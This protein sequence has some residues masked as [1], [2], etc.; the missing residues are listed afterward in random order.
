MRSNQSKA[1]HH[2]KGSHRLLWRAS[3]LVLTT[4][5]CTTDR[6]P[7]SLERQ[8]TINRVRT[9]SSSN[10]SNGRPVE[11]NLD[12]VAALR[13]SIATEKDPTSHKVL[14]FLHAFVNRQFVE[15]GTRD[16]ERD[17]QALRTS[18]VGLDNLTLSL[19]NATKFLA[20]Q[21]DPKQRRRFAEAVSPSLADLEPLLKIRDRHIA[22]RARE[23]ALPD[24][25]ALA[26]VVRNYDVREAANV[27]S[28]LLKTSDALYLESLRDLVRV[29]GTLPLEE[30]GRP[31]IPWLL[32]GT[33]NI[34]ADRLLAAVHATVMLLDIPLTCL[35]RFVHLPEPI[36]PW[37]LPRSQTQDILHA[38]GHSLHQCGCRAP[39]FELCHLG[40]RSV[41]EAFAVLLE[42]L[43]TEPTWLQEQLGMEEPQL[44]IHLHQAALARLLTARLH[45]A[46]VLDEVDRYG[47][48][49]AQ[50]KKLYAAHMSRALG[51]SFA[52]GD[53]EHY[54]NDRDPFI[55]SA[56]S[57]RGHIIAAQIQ[58]ELITRFGDSWWRLPAAGDF[59][60]ELWLTGQRD[61]AEELLA[62]LGDAGN[63]DIGEN[64]AQPILNPA[65]LVRWTAT[66]LIRQVPAATLPF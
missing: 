39:A 62:R 51:V 33:A 34:E 61:T 42:G 2:H 26:G 44:T 29:D 3:L 19:A 28:A 38:A 48:N 52:P 32:R 31:D 5:A 35:D 41:A 63:D 54:E 17:I 12:Q 66:R 1:A 43:L 40:D 10:I 53:A 56:D 14:T 24:G 59:L 27:A 15:Q 25:L 47:R 65:P 8:H 6:V 37:D 16:L 49:A 22:D 7:A 18:P 21:S 30:V 36:H 4:H 64:H 57:L 55:D 20:T 13:A 11:F 23:L 9:L 45:A 46:R 58:T 50:A 60:K